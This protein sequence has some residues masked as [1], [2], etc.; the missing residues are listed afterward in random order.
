MSY[1]CHGFC[2]FPFCFSSWQN[3]CKFSW[4]NVVQPRMFFHCLDVFVPLTKYFVPNKSCMPRLLMHL[5]CSHVFIVYTS[6]DKCHDI[7]LGHCMEKH[8]P[9][10]FYCYC[11]IWGTEWTNLAY[12]WQHI[13]PGEWFLQKQLVSVVNFFVTL[14]F[15]CIVRC[16]FILK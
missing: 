2:N 12:T 6:I 8:N 3:C 7:W 13:R 4:V 5:P 14:C 16:V 9:W 1:I 11:W 15:S 10:L